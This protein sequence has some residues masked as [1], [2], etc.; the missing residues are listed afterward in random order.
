[1]LDGYT[2]FAGRDV[3]VTVKRAGKTIGIAMGTLN[4]DGFL[5]INH[6]SAQCWDLITPDIRGGDV[7][8][9]TF[10]GSDL[11]EGAI[12]GSAVVTGV[13]AGA[14]SPTP[15]VS[16]DV[17]ATVTI[18]GTY[19]VDDPVIDPERFLVEVVNPDMRDAPSA[20][21]ERAI[22]WGPGVNAVSYTHLTLPTK[23]IV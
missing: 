11:V 13:E 15:D 18:S 19:D 22:A 2:E 3:T 8:E 14:V 5:E 23:R 10:A 12:T 20:I 1:M 17:E 6:D 16:G 21:G 4:S 7:V 9:A